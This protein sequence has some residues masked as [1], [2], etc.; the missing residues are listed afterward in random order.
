MTES[1][2]HLCDAA[3]H[4][5]GRH[6]PDRAVGEHADR[7]EHPE[8]LFY[9]P[10]APES[11]VETFRLRLDDLGIAAEGVAVLARNSDWSTR[12]M[13]QPARSRATTGPDCS[14]RRPTRTAGQ[15]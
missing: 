13:G 15:P 5:C 3:V 14:A 2:Q 8:I 6:E 10:M 4:F 1:S 12:S 7:S 9:E 11:V